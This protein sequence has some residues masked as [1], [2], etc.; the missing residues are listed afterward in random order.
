MVQRIAFKNKHRFPYKLSKLKISSIQIT[1]FL[2]KLGPCIYLLRSERYT[3]LE[4]L[5]SY[6]YK[7]T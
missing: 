6:L 3:Y 1:A 5:K 7:C 2:P 4:T